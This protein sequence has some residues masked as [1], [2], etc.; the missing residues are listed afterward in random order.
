MAQVHSPDQAEVYGTQR[1][2]TCRWARPVSP[3]ESR[4]RAKPPAPSR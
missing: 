2:S 3:R 4:H 1:A